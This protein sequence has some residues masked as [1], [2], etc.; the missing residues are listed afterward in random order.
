MRQKIASV[1][2]GLAPF[3]GFNEAVF[4]LEVKRTDILHN[5]NGVAALLGGSLRKL[6]LQV[7]VEVNFHAPKNT[8][9]PAFGQC[10]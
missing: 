5:L 3:D 10:R 8:G 9:K 1:Q 6:R 4:F 2:S 7:G